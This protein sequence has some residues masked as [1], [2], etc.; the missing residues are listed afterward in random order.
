M[1]AV[2]RYCLLYAL[3]GAKSSAAADLLQRKLPCLKH[4]VSNGVLP[5]AATIRTKMG[6]TLKFC[7]ALLA[8]VAQHVPQHSWTCV[9]A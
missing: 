1:L 3:E 2:L 9:P 7:T 8:G 5:S 4:V 6:I